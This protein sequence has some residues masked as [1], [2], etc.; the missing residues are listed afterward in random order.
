MMY[1]NFFTVLLLLTVAEAKE[2]TD[3]NASY[4]DDTHATISNKVMDWSGSLDDTLSGW[5]G[6]DETNTTNLPSK[7]ED[8]IEKK[9]LYVDAFFRSNKFLDETDETFVKIRFDGNVQTKESNDFKARLSAQIPFI[10]SRQNFKF[11]VNDLT[12]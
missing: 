5:L 6:Y 10:K 9:V 4:I 12:I 2:S 1:R 11:F 8:V 3:S 7:P